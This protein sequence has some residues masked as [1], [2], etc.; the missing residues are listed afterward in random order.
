MR[1]I[2]TSS[3]LFARLSLALTALLVTLCVSAPAWARRAAPWAEGGP[4]NPQ[5][6]RIELATF[7]PGLDVPSWFGHTAIAVTDERRGVRRVYNYGMFSFDST[8][9]PK[10]LMG[11]L[12]FWVGPTSY[13]G[14]MRLYAKQDRDVR[15]LELNLPPDKRAEVA[16][17]LEDNIKPENRD[18]LYHHY[19]DNC[20]TRIRD[21]IDEATDGQFAE[22]SKKPARMSLRDHTRRHARW[23]ILDFGMSYAMSATIDRPITAWE[24]MYL[25]VELEN[26]VKAFE[27]TTEDGEKIPLAGEERVIHTSETLPETPEEPST[28]WPLMLFGGLLFGASGWLLMRR[29]RQEPRRGRRVL[30]GLH[31]AFIGGTFGLAGALLTFMWAFTDHQVVYNNENILQTNP[32]TLLLLPLG[33]MFAFGSTR[34]QRW[35]PRLWL[36]LA[37]I[38]SLGVILKVLPWFDQQN[39]LTLALCVPMFA[40]MAHA[41]RQAI[42]AEG[43]G[44]PAK[45]ADASEDEQGEA[46]EE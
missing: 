1:T 46:G 25:P 30:V 19:D 2:D 4:S 44:A 27:Y 17:F 34:A 11:R 45:P 36:A 39:W 3:H 8:V 40:F 37:V 9:V 42:A 24:E 41:S 16:R 33:L 38:A 13:A 15:L 12:E 32:L 43:E 10:Y 35:L 18:Y 28:L 7:G 21:I 29:W 5:D 26:N 23:S 22:F 31:S 14:T 6:L 20:A